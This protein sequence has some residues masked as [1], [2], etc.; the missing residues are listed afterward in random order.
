MVTVNSIANY[1]FNNDGGNRQNVYHDTLFLT[2]INPEHGGSKLLQN[3]QNCSSI[4]MACNSTR[5][6]TSLELP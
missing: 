3:T 4:Y 1:L 6:E 5:R 2:C